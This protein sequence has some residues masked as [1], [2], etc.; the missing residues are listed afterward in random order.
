MFTIAF[1][2]QVMIDDKWVTI[3]NTLTYTEPSGEKRSVSGIGTF[4]LKMTS[5]FEVKMQCL[6]IENDKTKTENLDEKIKP[7][8]VDPTY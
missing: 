7:N 3:P 6:F 2:L 8:Y 4:P 1:R 5:T